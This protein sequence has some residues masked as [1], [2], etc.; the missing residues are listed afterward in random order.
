M[1]RFI[2]AIRQNRQARLGRVQHQATTQCSHAECEESPVQKAEVKMPKIS[3]EARANCK[4]TRQQ[5][6]PEK[7]ACA[8]GDCNVQGGIRGFIDP[9]NHNPLLALRPYHQETRQVFR[10]EGAARR[11]NFPRLG[12]LGQRGRF[13]VAPVVYARRH[14][15][16]N[17]EDVRTA[18]NRRNL[19][20]DAAIIG[21][22]AGAGGGGAGAALIIK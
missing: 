12:A 3:P 22:T 5:C 16:V 19:L 8:T 18:L 17:C 14:P 9:R 20:I 15:G 13:L 21:G 6:A 10:E 7:S 2:Q 11:P 4:A 1:G